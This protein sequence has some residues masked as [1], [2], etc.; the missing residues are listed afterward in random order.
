[1]YEVSPLRYEDGNFEVLDQTKLPGSE[2][3]IRIETKE[4]I[5]DAIR[6]LKVRGAPAIGV[7]AAFGLYMSVK[8][9]HP[10]SFD[11]FYRICRENGEYINSSRPTAVNLSWAVRR[12]LSL[13]GS[14]DPEKSGDSG[15]E[16]WDDKLAAIKEKMRLEAVKIKEEDEEACRMIGEYGLRL[17]SPGMGILTHCN[18]GA[19][20]TSKYGTCL[21][22]IHLGQ[23]K[24]YDFH[25]FCDETRPLLQG[26]RLTAWE[27]MKS[28]VDTTLICDNMAATVMKKG[29]I[30]AVV[31]GCDRM[32]ANGDGANKIGTSGVAILA[33]EFNI[34]FY[35][36]VPTSTIDLDTKTGDDIRIE[37]RDGD[38]IYR[39][40][41]KKDMAPAGVKTF[42]PAF[43][44]TDHEN[45]TA[46][47]T[48]KGIVRPPFDVNLA[49]VVNGGKAE[50]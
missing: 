7:S 21:A 47:V 10:A 17:L 36:F 20:A 27:L 2:E 35:M 4:D 18:A 14:L 48:E 45:I 49:A 31:V 50:D 6:E 32:A 23:E 37:E 39:M 15:D 33:K 19:L 16:N 41:Y 11:E 26:A 3:W 13:V 22:P 1:M 44:V 12:M 24:G 29:W 30:D 40:W 8:D 9:E 42:N 46:V 25:V 43:D 34:P 38:E 28:G 5:W